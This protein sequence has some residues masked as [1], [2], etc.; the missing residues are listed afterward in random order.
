MKPLESRE[1][2]IWLLLSI[3]AGLGCLVL[4][5][6]ATFIVILKESAFGDKWVFTEITFISIPKS[7]FNTDFN[8]VLEFKLITLLVIFGISYWIFGL[9]SF[10]KILNKFPILFKKLFFL[11]SLIG[12]MTSIYEVFWNFNLWNAKI[13]SL[14]IQNPNFI[15]IDMDGLAYLNP[16]FPVNLNFATK[17]YL[18]ALFFSLYGVY[19]FYSLIGMENHLK[20]MS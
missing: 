15:N 19:Y 20:K 1:E 18:L 17:M 7:L 12:V 8:I 3:I 16:I 4:W 6:Y 10:R 13:V 14:A 11:I 9:E 5:L 2:K